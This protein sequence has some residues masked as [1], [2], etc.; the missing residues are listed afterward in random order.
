MNLFIY[1]FMY[2]FI[3][4]FIFFFYFPI[5]LFIHFFIYQVCFYL[6][7]LFQMNEVLWNSF[8]KQFPS[9]YDR[10]VYILF[11]CE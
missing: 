5:Y 1:L 11:L 7:L 10:H 3:C 8:F 2:L 6:N 4:L 9:T